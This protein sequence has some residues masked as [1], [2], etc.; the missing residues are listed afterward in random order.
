MLIPF[1]DASFSAG[2]PHSGPF[3]DAAHVED[4]VMV[5]LCSGAGARVS[6]APSRSFERG[7][8]LP[9]SSVIHM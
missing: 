6:E 9:I 8:I 1:L 7:L 4:K 3:I 5:S 2:R